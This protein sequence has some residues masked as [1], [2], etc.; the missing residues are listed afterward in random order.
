MEK[1]EVAIGCSGYLTKSPPSVSNFEDLSENTMSRWRS[2]W[3]VQQGPLLQYYAAPDCKVRKGFIFLE[4]SYLFTDISVGAYANILCVMT[5][6]RAY[7]LLAAS[8]PE[9]QRWRAALSVFCKFRT[10]RPSIRSKHSM[11]LFIDPATL[12]EGVDPSTWSGDE[13]DNASSSNSSAITTIPEESAVGVSASVLNT[14][15]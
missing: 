12:P 10:E 8:P 9:H 2:R 13:E 3:F 7:F 4:N 11:S 14:S 1:V 15:A 5:R 6:A